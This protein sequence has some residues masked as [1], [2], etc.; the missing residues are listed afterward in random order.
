MYVIDTNVF[1]DWWE[2]RYP[3]DVFPSVQRQMN[4]ELGISTENVRA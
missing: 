2:R 1:L 3:P 4:G